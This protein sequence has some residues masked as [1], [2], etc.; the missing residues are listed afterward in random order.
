MKV[1]DAGNKSV[2][3]GKINMEIDCFCMYY[4]TDAFN[5]GN[6][7]KK[8]IVDLNKIVETVKRKVI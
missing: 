2:L 7:R 5:T 1:V 6:G 4:Y 3:W 8:D